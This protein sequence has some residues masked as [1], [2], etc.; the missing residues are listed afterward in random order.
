M[1]KHELIELANARMPFGKYKGTL[2]LYLR[3]DYLVWMKQK[4][5]PAGKLGR[6]MELMYEI[7]MN[8]LENML[9]PLIEK[10]L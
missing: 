8:G 1:Q 10:N 5:W 9:R 4:G 7:K 6:Q 2:L 3:E